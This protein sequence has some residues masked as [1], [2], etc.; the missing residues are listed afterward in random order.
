MMQ[1]DEVP[2]FVSGLLGNR[3]VRWSSQ[4]IASYDGQDR[5]LE[6]FEA[7]ASEQRELLRALRPVRAELQGAA[8]GPLVIVFHTRAESER[9]HA[10][11]V[12][13]WR[14]QVRQKPI[15]FRLACPPPPW[16]DV[17]VREGQVRPPR[18]VA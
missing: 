1:R 15:P 7:D 10:E 13:G 18:R 9:L 17:D 14:A 12:R 2:T 8:G 16:V 11:F 6:V 4:A 5:A 3:P